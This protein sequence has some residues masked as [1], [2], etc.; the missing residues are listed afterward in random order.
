MKISIPPFSHSCPTVFCKPCHS[1]QVSW[2]FFACSHCNI[3]H[4][5]LN[6]WGNNIKWSEHHKTV[7]WRTIGEEASLTSHTRFCTSV[8]A[9]LSWWFLQ[10]KGTILCSS[11][12]IV[13]PCSCR[14]YYRNL[15]AA[16]NSKISFF[17]LLKKLI[18][19]QCYRVSVNSWQK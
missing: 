6:H 10:K 13:L 1:G 3:R 18:D 9:S 19:F 8:F 15:L 2:A 11:A 17:C 7:S 5:I 12:L 14:K 4:W 16:P